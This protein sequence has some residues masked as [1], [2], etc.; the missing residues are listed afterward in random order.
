MRYTRRM[1]LQIT[2]EPE[3][4]ARVRRLAALQKRTAEEVVLEALR[5]SVPAKPLPSWI[6]MG[7]SGM[8]DLSERAEELL[9][10]GLETK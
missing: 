9:S 4:E 6:G 2:L 10:H 7:Y 5:N 3:L 1:T 8:S